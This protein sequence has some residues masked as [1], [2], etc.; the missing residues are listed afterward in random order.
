MYGVA[1]ATRMVGLTLPQLVFRAGLIES[2]ALSYDDN[3]AFKIRGK[4]KKLQTELDTDAMEKSFSQ[5]SFSDL[6]NFLLQPA[7][8]ERTSSRDYI[9]QIIFLTSKPEYQLC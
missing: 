3:D 9:D 2:E 8:K 1:G 4:L 6:S 7:L 5:L